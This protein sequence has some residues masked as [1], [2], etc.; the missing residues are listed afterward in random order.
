MATRR[1]GRQAG[2][3]FYPHVLREAPDK[4][5]PDIVQGFHQEGECGECGKKG[6]MSQFDGGPPGS[7]ERHPPKC[8]G[9]GSA[10]ISI[11][12]VDTEEDV[13]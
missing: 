3:G 11:N 10:Q 13:G 9:C 7:P 8:P 4:L 6:P 1:T 2:P 12:S 5:T